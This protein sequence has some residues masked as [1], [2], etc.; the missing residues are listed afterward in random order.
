MMWREGDRDRGKGRGVMGGWGRR[1]RGGG[2]HGVV[3]TKTALEGIQEG[4]GGG[5][6]PQRCV[7]DGKWV[8]VPVDPSIITSIP[9]VGGDRWMKSSHP[10]VVG[11][12]TA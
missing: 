2:G 5:G 3:G 12:T 10:T 6:G 9:T 8:V 4:R 11:G 1:R 7:K